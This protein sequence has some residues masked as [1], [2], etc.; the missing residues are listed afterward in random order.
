MTS[1]WMRSTP[2]KVEA[3]PRWPEVLMRCVT[4]TSPPELAYIRTI[5]F[6]AFAAHGRDGTPQAGTSL[7]QLLRSRVRSGDRPGRRT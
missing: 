1:P 2:V 3:T 6:C 7:F 5:I 4:L